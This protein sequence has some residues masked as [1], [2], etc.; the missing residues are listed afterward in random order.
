MEISPGTYGRHPYQERNSTAVVVNYIATAVASHTR[1]LRDSFEVPTGKSVK[2]CMLDTQMIRNATA[3]ADVLVTAEY[4]LFQVGNGTEC[5]HRA[6]LFNK[7]Q[8]ASS[9]HEHD[10]GIYINEGDILNIYTTDL[11]AA[12][13]V[14]YAVQATLQLYDK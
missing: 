10:P 1:T 5:L 2:I 7:L 11:S 3:P 8:G 14:N 4:E 12:G 13:T 9:H 6:D